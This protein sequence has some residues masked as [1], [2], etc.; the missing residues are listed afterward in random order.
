M[1][2]RRS[3]ALDSLLLNGMLIV[4]LSCTP[5]QQGKGSIQWKEQGFTL[6]YKVASWLTDPLCAVH[7]C[8]R[9]MAIVEAHYPDASDLERS[10]RKSLLLLGSSGH[11]LLSLIT[12]L[13]GIAFRCLAILLQNRPYIYCSGEGEE[14]TLSEKSLLCLC[15]VLHY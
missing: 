6:L 10:V 4:S 5:L 15:G 8:Y 11:A 1:R 13:P 12:T 2:Y 14:K 9:Q 3:F 7:R